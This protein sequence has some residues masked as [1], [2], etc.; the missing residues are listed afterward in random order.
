MK[1]EQY[2]KLIDI[3]QE[4][5]DLD[6]KSELGSINE[7][8]KLAE[9]SELFGIDLKNKSF[10]NYIHLNY[11]NTK[12]LGYFKE[13]SISWSDDGRQPEGEWLYRLSYPCG[14]YTFHSDYPTETFGKFI[15]EIKSYNP[16][17]S[18]TCNKSFYFS[19]ENA[20]TI[21][22]NI[23]TIFSKYLSQVKDELKKMKIKK[24]ENELTKLNSGE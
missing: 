4:Y 10:S 15:D 12:S 20:K 17:Y 14:A 9:L 19:P 23:D 7:K 21:H 5:S 13:G 22:D 11:D 2:R 1:S 24:L 8:L 6:I 16:K 18:D 3:M